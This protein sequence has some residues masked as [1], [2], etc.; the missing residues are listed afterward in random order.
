VKTVYVVL[1]KK[2]NVKPVSDVARSHIFVSSQIILKFI[3]SCELT[4]NFYMG[5]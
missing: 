5:L 3:G 1:Q 2:A 4:A